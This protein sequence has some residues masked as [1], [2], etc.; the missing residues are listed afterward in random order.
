M[1]TNPV[2]RWMKVLFIAFHLCVIVSWAIPGV[3]VFHIWRIWT[4]PYVSWIGLS[5]SWDLFA[6]DPL[7]TSHH[8]EARITY[9]DGRR[10]I[11][12]FPRADRLGVW[13][14]TL[15]MRYRKLM[16]HLALD[17]SSAL[18]PDVARF[19]ARHT[20][21]HGKRPQTVELIRYASTVLPPGR[22]NRGPQ[23]W[24][25]AIFFTYHVTPADLP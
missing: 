1:D 10:A 22:A 15:K 12:S 9:Q 4:G 14:R 6:P 2:L 19:V 20:D 13:Q 17:Q 11:W 16:D 7:R 23:Q 3:S 18:W 25:S 21:T 24:H 5:Q 8:V